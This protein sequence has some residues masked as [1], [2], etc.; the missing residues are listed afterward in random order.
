MPPIVKI[1]GPRFS[2]PA[3]PP[4][5]IARLNFLAHL[6]L[7]DAT[8]GSTPEALIGSIMPDL[9]RGKLPSTLPAA[10][11]AAAH[12]H[13]KIDAFTDTHPIVARS[14]QRLF[15][16]PGSHARYTGILIDIFY[17]HFLASDWPRWSDEPRPAFIARVHDAFRLRAHLMPDAMRYP[18]DRMIEQDWLASY[19]TMDGIE[20][21]LTRLSARLTQRF[22]REV[23]LETAIPDLRAH[24]SALRDDFNTFFPAL[25]R[26]ASLHSA[27]PL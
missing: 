21:A 6:H 15:A 14:K 17:D 1:G 24:E 23:H 9:V 8:P 19:A 13:R 7:C 18:I 10:V 12:Q 26:Y 16:I 25:K 20:L 3:R 22:E 27:G 4:T 2:G 5:T 11:L